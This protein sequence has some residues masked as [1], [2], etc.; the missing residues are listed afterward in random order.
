VTDPNRPAGPIALLGYSVESMEAATELG[1]PFVAVVPE[2]FVE[3][4]ER[5]DIPVQGWDFALRNEES[6]RLSEKLQE[7]GVR[8]AV[9]LYE[10]TVE[11]AGAVNGRL[12]DDPRAFQRSLLFRDKA[13]MKR[14]A[15]MQGIR[16][17]VFEEVASRDDALQF[18][19]RVNQALLRTGEDVA[20]PVHVKPLNA[21]GSVGHVVINSED[22]ID[23]LPLEAFPCLAESHMSGREFSVEAFVHDGKIRFMNITEYVHLGYSQVVPASSNLERHRGRIQQA[24][25]KLVRAFQVENGMIHPEYFIDADGDLNFGE[26]AARV[27]GGHIFEL[28][29]EAHG[30]NAYGAY[31]LCSD[32]DVDS[33]TLDRFFPADGPAQRYA[34]NLMVYPRKPEVHEVQIPKD[35]LEHPYFQR[36]DMFE[37]VTSKVQERVGFGNHYGTIFFAGEDPEVLRE[38]V[39]RYE[40]Y[41]F[42]V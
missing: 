23:S 10:E 33:D 13:M 28:I 15:Q 3:A 12:R 37:P 34:A 7:R 5:D 19:R 6:G 14:N 27:P 25:E 22:D 30:F 11:W 4:L 32:P 31:L 17:G 8:V 20:D 2:P 41:D 24:V 39:E 42:Y 26:V 36:H 1:L 29:R 9:P 35:L 18:F 16:V 40:E 38:L 21:A